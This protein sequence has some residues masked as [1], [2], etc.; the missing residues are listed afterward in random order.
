MKYIHRQLIIFS[1]GIS[2]G[3]TLFAQYSTHRDINVKDDM[4][5]FVEFMTGKQN[6]IVVKNQKHKLPNDLA[7][8][9]TYW[10]RELKKGNKGAK[11]ATDDSTHAVLPIAEA[12]SIEDKYLEFTHWSPIYNLGKVWGGR[13]EFKRND[14]LYEANY[15]WY[16]GKLLD[17]M[18]RPFL[19][20]NPNVNANSLLNFR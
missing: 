5:M 12:L 3:V 2:V 8:K 9:R 4:L 14:K 13:V 11:P 10:Q 15:F 20:T 17:I 19:D 18:I 1:L 7:R 16:N 6:Y